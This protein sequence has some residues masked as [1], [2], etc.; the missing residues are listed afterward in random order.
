M[1]SIKIP[2]L[3]LGLA[4]IIVAILIYFSKIPNHLNQEKGMT[5]LRQ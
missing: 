1:D 3:C 4:F 5:L 2:Y